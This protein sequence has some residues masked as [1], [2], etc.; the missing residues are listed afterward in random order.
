MH[1]RGLQTNNLCLLICIKNTRS[2]TFLS[3]QKIKKIFLPKF[4]YLLTPFTFSLFYFRLH[5]LYL[6]CMIKNEY[7]NTRIDKKLCDMQVNILITV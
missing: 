2:N 4:T 7:H 3:R 6:Q 1:Y 5:L